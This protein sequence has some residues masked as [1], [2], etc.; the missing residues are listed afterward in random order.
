MSRT[1]YIGRRR[2]LY[3]SIDSSNTFTGS[4]FGRRYRDGKLFLWCGWLR[5]MYTHEFSL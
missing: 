2:W 3:V 5:L 1:F 4:A